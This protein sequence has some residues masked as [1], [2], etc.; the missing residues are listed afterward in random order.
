VK[1]KTERAEKRNL[2]LSK[3]KKKVCKPHNHKRKK[4]T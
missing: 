1:V 2:F 4:I 3:R